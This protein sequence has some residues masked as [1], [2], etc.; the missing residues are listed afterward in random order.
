MTPRQAWLLHL[1]SV[2]VSG[3]GAAYFI[4]KYFVISD[5]PFSVVNHPLQPAMLKI[6]ILT[7]PLLVLG[8][9]LVFEQ[10]IASKLRLKTASNR[11]SGL[12]ALACYP[13]MILS[14]YLLQVLAD[15]GALRLAMIVHCVSGGL[16][17]LTYLMHVTLAL[18]LVRAHHRLLRSGQV[19]V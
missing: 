17:S 8:L 11:I 3:S 5:D 6:H 15:A 4:V 7:A 1:S 19:A 14:G 2:L 10:H 16:F 13:P 18:L 9:G 12:L